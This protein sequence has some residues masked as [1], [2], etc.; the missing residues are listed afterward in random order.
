[1][2]HKDSLKDI[3]IECNAALRD[4]LEK[5]DNT[6]QQILLVVDETKRLVG[7]FT[8]GDFRRFILRNQSLNVPIK[9]AMNRSFTV[10]NQQ[11]KSKAYDILKKSRFNHIPI[12]DNQGKVV[13]LITSLDFIK[14]EIVHHDI[15]VVIMA[16]GKGSR[17]AP[18]T[19][20]IPKPLMPVGDKTMIEMILEK[21]DSQ[22]FKNFYVIAN[23]KKELIKSYFVERNIPYKVDFIDEMDFLGTAGGLS[24]LKDK[25]HSPFV[26]TNCDIIANINYKNLLDWHVEHEAHLTILGVKKIIDVP[27]GVININEDNY[28]TSIDEKPCYNLMI[29]SG[30]FVVEPSLLDLI[31]ENTFYQMDQFIGDCIRQSKK[32][33]CYPVEKDWFDIGQFKEY[34]QLLKHFG[35]MND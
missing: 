24:L 9:E 18:L 6:G 28:V 17:L 25:I 26:L 12:V 7:I 29:V 1:M 34:N 16:G 8:D 10:L 2:S 21:F 14:T 5:L 13:D 15:P 3:I 11:D 33:A 31:P 32:I 20:I 30:I 19:F 4:A 23:Y 27:Y 35:I 22:G